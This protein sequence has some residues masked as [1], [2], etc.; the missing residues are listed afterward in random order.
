MEIIDNINHLLGENLKHTIKPNAKLKIAAAS[1]SIYAYA[2]LKR[3]LESIDSLQFIFTS[4]TFVPHEVSDKI[5][6]AQREFHI[7]KAGRERDFFG[8]EFEIQLKN[9]LT[10]RAI[11]KECADWMCRSINWHRKPSTCRPELACRK[12]RYLTSA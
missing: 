4:P 9:K 12:F 11:A 5:K 6:K 3:E 8:S 1:F 2:A 7:P 10:Q